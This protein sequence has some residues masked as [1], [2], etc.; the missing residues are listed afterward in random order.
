MFEKWK[1][2]THWGQ[3]VVGPP[4]A[5]KTTYCKSLTH[6]Y[7]QLPVNSRQVCWINLDP[8]NEIDVSEDDSPVPDIDIT[9]LVTLEDVMETTKLGPNGG[10]IHC[11][12]IINENF[13]WLEQKILNYDSEYFLIDIP[14]QIELSTISNSPLKKLIEK[15]TDKNTFDMRLTCVHLTD[16]TYC[17]DSSRYISAIMTSLSSMIQLELP[18]INILS[19]LDL[20]KNLN[21]KEEEDDEES[22]QVFSLSF[23]TGVVDLERLLE[24][25]EFVERLPARQK[26]M[27]R[28]IAAVVEDYSLV[29]FIP[30][31]VQDYDTISQVVQACDVS[32]GYFSVEGGAMTSAMQLPKGFDDGYLRDIENKFW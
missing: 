24:N 5:G 18:H 16:A 22:D 30:M 2:S 9:N 32:N 8:A 21:K 25:D 23:Y 6:V 17:L 19:K 31:S 20:A 7:P 27:L 1:E 13:T 3:V 14:G 4:G 15:L 29:R 11:M 28:K 10:L 26:K 12:E